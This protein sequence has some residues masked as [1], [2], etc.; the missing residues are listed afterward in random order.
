QKAAFYSWGGQQAHGLASA[1]QLQGKELSYNNIVDLD[2]AWNLI[3]EL[4]RPACCIIKHTNPCGAAVGASLRE[5][6]GK[7]YEAGNVTA[8]GSII[9]VNRPVDVEAATEVGN[10][11]VEAIIAPGYAS[12]ATGIFAAKKNLRVLSVNTAEGPQDWARFE[13]RKVSGGLLL[14]TT[15]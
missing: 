13:I 4:A 15:D 10:L 3:Q 5:V 6:Y 1:Q 12:E 8:F 2:A 9:A 14:Q 7:A 11:F